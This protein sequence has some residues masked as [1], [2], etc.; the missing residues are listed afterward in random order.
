MDTP[1]GMEDLV[2][3]VDYAGFDGFGSGSAFDNIALPLRINGAQ[4][5]QIGTVVAEMMGWLGLAEPGWP[6]EVSV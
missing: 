4:H 3:G 1:G 5:E 2:F 6:M